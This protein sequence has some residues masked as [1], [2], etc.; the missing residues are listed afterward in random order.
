MLDA[1]STAVVVTPYCSNL[2]PST[3]LGEHRA[4]SAQQA[5]AILHATAL[6]RRKADFSV[7]LSPKFF[8]CRAVEARASHTVCCCRGSYPN[9]HAWRTYSSTSSHT[10]TRQISTVQSITAVSSSC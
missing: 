10:A 5:P 4:M 9:P 1:F 2:T 6:P 3:A 7:A 8:L